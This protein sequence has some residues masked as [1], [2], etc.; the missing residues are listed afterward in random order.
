MR[1]ILGIVVATILSGTGL[2]SGQIS[3]QISGGQISGPIVIDRRSL[4]G[5]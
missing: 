1:L 4:P 5:Q 2:I 3:G